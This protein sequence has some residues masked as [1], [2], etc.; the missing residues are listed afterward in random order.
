[1][2]KITAKVKL[3]WSFF[4]LGF[5]LERFTVCGI[6]RADKSAIV[7]FRAYLGPVVCIVE[8][9]V[10]EWRDDKTDH[11]RNERQCSL[12]ALYHLYMLDGNT[13]RAF[14]VQVELKRSGWLVQ[15]NEATKSCKLIGLDTGVKLPCY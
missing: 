11:D 10:K 8:A 9:I 4:G 14:E 15:W 6:E 13:L 1:M 3:V 7:S 2:K 5:G 12:M